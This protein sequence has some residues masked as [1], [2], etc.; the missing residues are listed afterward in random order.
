MI[1]MI[2]TIY[3][4]MDE[5]TLVKTTGEVDTEIEHTTWVEYR[6]HNSDEII[7]RSVHVTVKDSLLLDLIQGQ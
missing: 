6:Q 1:N 3:G 2:N 5:N 4:E 7:H